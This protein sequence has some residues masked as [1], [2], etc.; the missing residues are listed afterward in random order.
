MVD[1]RG[2]K[3]DQH[4]QGCD[5][6]LETLGLAYLTRFTSVTLACLLNLQRSNKRHDDLRHNSLQTSK[7]LVRM[8][9]QAAANLSN[10]SSYEENA[11]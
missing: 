4:L 9:N 5:V 7:R 8:V 11:F 2:R 1:Q 6:D 10:I 3:L